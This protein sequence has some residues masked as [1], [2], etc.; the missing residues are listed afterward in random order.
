MSEKKSKKNLEAKG[1]VYLENF[2]KIKYPVNFPIDSSVFPD[3]PMSEKAALLYG[4][5]QLFG[6]DYD[7]GKYG[8]TPVSVKPRGLELIEH[9]MNVSFN[10]L[11][12]CLEELCSTGWIESVH[13][14]LDF[15]NWELS[16]RSD[17]VSPDFKLP[18]FRKPIYLFNK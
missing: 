17:T 7:C 9:W 11:F 8:V 4:Y 10:E 18:R 5:L 12:C 3:P 14:S 2:H 16:L 6:D 13:V 1:H 15:R